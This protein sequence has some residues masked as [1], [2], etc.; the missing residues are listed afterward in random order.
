MKNPPILRVLVWTLYFVCVSKTALAQSTEYEIGD[1]ASALPG[2]VRV[3]V[4]GPVIRKGPAFAGGAGYAFTES[5][6]GTNDKHNRLFGVLAASFRP[7]DLVAVGVRLDGRYDWHRNVPEGNGGGL[8]GEP[9]LLVRAG[10][11]AHDLRFGAEAQVVV[12]GRDAPSIEFKAITPELSLL[13]AYAPAS[14]PLTFA[15]R[16]GFRLDRTKEAVPDVDRLSRA[17]RLSLGVSDTNAL[18][19]GAGVVGRVAPRWEALG[20][21]TWDLRVP[22]KGVSAMASPMRVDA[23]AR[24]TPNERGTLQLQL[25]LE[26]SPNARPTIG[27]GE[28][29]VPVEPR[30]SV[31]A[32]INFRPPLAG[33]VEPEPRPVVEAPPPARTA[34]SV[35]LRVIDEGGRP[36][37]GAKLRFGP[38]GSGIEATTDD[39]GKF[40]QRDLPAGKTDIN[41][42]AEGYRERST[43][44]E[45][46]TGTFDLEIQL[47]R[48][49]P[50]GQIRGLVRSFAGAPISKATVRVGPIG[51]EVVVG[52]GGR[53][54]LDVP[55]GDYDVIVKAP[56]YA[57][58]QRRVHVEANG[59]VV[60]DL[61]MRTRR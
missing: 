14:G 15:S 6:L 32:A 26:V 23:G 60:L 29:L 22:S 12:P 11:K 25:L 59:V 45:V 44:V 35:R 54:E 51:K 40:E 10:T 42:T 8:I 56:G 19:L 18:L 41:V 36:V 1:T 3:P 46:K 20:E 38:P 50:V 13:A 5:V 61:D 30:L 39:Q 24:Y 31:F 34:G 2:V 48:V 37:S 53:F 47:Q 21:W 33:A 52:E 4:A 49:L 17:D 43:S 57:D 27:P 58:Q 55:P 9:R 16:L 7:N 28:P